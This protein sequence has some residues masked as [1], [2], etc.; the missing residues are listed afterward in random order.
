MYV[1]VA[2]C[3]VC[4]CSRLHAFDLLNLDNYN[5]IY[6]KERGEYTPGETE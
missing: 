3:N 4:N 6:L 5:H 1:I 2:D